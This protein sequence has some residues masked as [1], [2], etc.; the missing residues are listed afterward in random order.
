MFGLTFRQLIYAFIFGL[1]SLLFFKRVGSEPL[2]YFLIILSSSLGVGFMFLNLG[3][4]LRDYWN[5]F[6]FQKVKAGDPKL[7]KFLEV[8]EIKDD[9]IITSKNKKISIIKIRP[10]L[11]NLS[12]PFCKFSSVF[13]VSLC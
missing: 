8:K 9:L 11:N 13:L 12:L 5:F 10:I 6:R 3:E 7:N 1:F 4:K 2:K